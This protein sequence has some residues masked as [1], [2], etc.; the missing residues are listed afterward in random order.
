[1]RRGQQAVDDSF[2]GVG[3]CIGDKGVDLGGRRRQPDQVERDPAEQRGLAGLGRGLQAFLL[4]ARED[5][6]V[7]GRARPVAS[8]RR[9]ES[10][11]GPARDR[12]SGPS[13]VRAPSSSSRRRA[14]TRPDRSTPS[15]GRSGVRAAGLRRAACGL[16][17]RAQ[18]R[19]APSGS[20]RCCVAT[21]AGPVLPPLNAAA[22][23]SRR[24]CPRDFFAL[25]HSKQLASRIGRMSRA[26]STDAGVWAG[27]AGDCAD[28]AMPTHI[29]MHAE[30]RKAGSHG[31]QRRFYGITRNGIIRRLRRLH[32][33]SNVQQLAYCATG[34][35]TTSGA[36]KPCQR[37]RGAR[38]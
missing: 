22:L 6:G 8:A 38:R 2:V 30:C 5:E 15:T 31:I 16:R 10:R 1:M 35:R 24:S 9:A 33:F 13:P 23:R 37:G 17:R 3:P 7:D 20:R 14:T 32:R 26:K 36:A 12:P 29:R 19:A 21:R 11:D 18:A 28:T 4:E 34:Y 27:F 25:W